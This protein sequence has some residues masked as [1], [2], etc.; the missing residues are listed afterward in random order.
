MQ[1]SALAVASS[2]APVHVITHMLAL[3][4]LRI[5]FQLADKGAHITRAHQVHFFY[6]CV[7][8]KD[9]RLVQLGSRPFTAWHFW[10]DAALEKKQ[11]ICFT[12]P[13]HAYAV[14]LR[15]C[16]QYLSIAVSVGVNWTDTWAVWNKLNWLDLWDEKEERQP[17]RRHHRITSPSKC[18]TFWNGFKNLYLKKNIDCLFVFFHS[19]SLQLNW[20]SSSFFFPVS[21]NEPTWW[22]FL[23]CLSCGGGG[24]EGSCWRPRVSAARGQSSSQ[25][26]K[27]NQKQV[28]RA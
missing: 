12:T 17:R 28:S 1:P 7:L 26:I 27:P 22:P 3:T 6:E 19:N 15:G 5:S 14:V 24:A 4:C 18:M 23:R 16:R 21:S 2:A 11:C 13:L 9:G 10:H 25:H 20:F 8:I